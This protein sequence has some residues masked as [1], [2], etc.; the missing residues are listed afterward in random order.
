[1]T[2][3]H[4]PE[5][6]AARSRARHIERMILAGRPPP[7]VAYDGIQYSQDDLARHRRIANILH[8]RDL[9][10]EAKGAAAR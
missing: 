10:M 6:Y 2:E 1:M 5:R 8:L 4:G 9:V 3:P 7:M